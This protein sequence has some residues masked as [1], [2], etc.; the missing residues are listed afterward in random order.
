MFE[1]GDIVRV[2]TEPPANRHGVHW[3]F[4]PK[5]D[6]M[7]GQEATITKVDSSYGYS[8]CGYKLSIDP[9][10]YYEEAWLIP[11]KVTEPITEEQFD[12]DFGELIAGVFN[13][14][15]AWWNWQTRKI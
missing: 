6:S 5:M 9:K 13:F 7:C 10:C 1:V 12:E 15:R 11:I 14:L 3:I 4:I 8:S 2:V